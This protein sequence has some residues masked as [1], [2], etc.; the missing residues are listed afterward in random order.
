MLIFGWGLSEWNIRPDSVIWAYSLLLGSKKR[1][2]SFY[3]LHTARQG[4]AQAETSLSLPCVIGNRRSVGA[5]V[6]LHELP[7]SVTRPLIQFVCR[8][9]VAK[10]PIVGKHQIELLRPKGLMINCTVYILDRFQHKCPT[11]ACYS[12]SNV[13]IWCFSFFLNGIFSINGLDKTSNTE[14]LIEN[15]FHQ[16]HIRI[17]HWPATSSEQPSQDPR[18]GRA[19]SGGWCVGGPYSLR[20][21]TSWGLAGCGGAERNMEWEEEG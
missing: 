9:N 12:F 6:A 16:C 10:R 4:K 7:H 2:H 14:T 8:R 19:G 18:P 15:C 21:R 1:T 11:C 5:W 13:W 3:L 20:G 17:K